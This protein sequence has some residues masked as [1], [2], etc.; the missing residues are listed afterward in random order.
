M[1]VT[2]IDDNEIQLK[3][4]YYHC[5]WKNEKAHANYCVNKFFI[6]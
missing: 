3:V 2:L 1:Q 5:E 4:H 6:Y